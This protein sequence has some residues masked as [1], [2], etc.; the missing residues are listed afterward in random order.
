MTKSRAVGNLFNIAAQYDWH[1]PTWRRPI[2]QEAK[3]LAAVKD[4]RAVG[5]EEWKVTA[6]LR[7]CYVPKSQFGI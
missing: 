5:V 7:D 1:A 4:C 6:I 3:T 2:D